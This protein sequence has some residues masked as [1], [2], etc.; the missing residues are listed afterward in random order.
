MGG[1]H[2]HLH[3]I[4]ILD[5]LH[6]LDSLAATVLALEIIGTH[7][8]D[9]TDLCHGDNGICLRDQILHRHIIL[10]ITDL[11]S[12]IITVLVCNRK[13]FFSDYTKKQLLIGKDC[14][15]LL[16]LLLQSCILCFKF[17]SFQSGQ[18]T[19]SHI[20]DCLCLCIGK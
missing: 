16:Y 1:R 20:N 5:R 13:N 17:L 2:E 10:I 19:K 15:Q 8:L 3:D 7:T 11:R 12:S 18:S 14:L 6:T 4:V 9:V